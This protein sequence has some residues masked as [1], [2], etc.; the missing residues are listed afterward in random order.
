MKKKILLAMLAVVLIVAMSV[1]GTLAFLSQKT[2]TPLKNTFIAAGGGKIIDDEDDDDDNKDPINP[3]VKGFFLVEHKVEYADN[4]Y[5]AV[6]PE[7]FVK[8][9]SYDKV[10]PKMNLFKDPLLTV[11]VENEAE[12]YI[13]VKV[14]SDVALNNALSYELTDDWTSLGGGVYV[15]KN[16][17]QTGADGIELNKVQIL[18]DNKVVVA[19]VDTFGDLNEGALGDLQ[20]CAYICQAQGF[21]DASAA[22]AGCFGS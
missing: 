8:T 3:N 22:W 1:A 7:E 18:K 5:S 15:Y 19:D 16:A 13:F 20:F 9:N 6:T 21:D 4:N 12:V 2:E 10:A 17:V 14:S 11:N